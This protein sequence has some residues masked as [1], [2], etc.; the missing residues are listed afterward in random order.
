MTRHR[1]A[2]EAES[3]A[4]AAR[5]KVGDKVKVDDEYGVITEVPALDA[6]YL[7][8]NEQF[9]SVRLDAWGWDKE[10]RKYRRGEELRDHA[11]DSLG[12]VPESKIRKA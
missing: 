2:T 4:E 9:Y 8:H 3:P 6:F 12:C 11:A 7:Q 10:A 1:T 5:Y